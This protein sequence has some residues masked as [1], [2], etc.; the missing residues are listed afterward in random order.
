MGRGPADGAFQD[1]MARE[2]TANERQIDYGPVQFL[3]K[4]LDVGG[5]FSRERF[6]IVIK[7]CPSVGHGQ[8]C[9]NGEVGI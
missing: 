1:V 8:V 2:V 6:M 3:V 7:K 5:G 9:Y 4:P